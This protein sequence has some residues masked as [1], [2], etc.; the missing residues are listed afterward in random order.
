M[1]AR[2]SVIII[3]AALLTAVAPTP[4]AALRVAMRNV[5]DATGAPVRAAI[6]VADQRVTQHGTA[7]TRL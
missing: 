6:N 7:P 2:L 1:I 5:A 3:V 4:S